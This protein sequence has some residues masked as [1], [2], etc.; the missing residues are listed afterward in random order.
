M[1]LL[2]ANHNWKSV[3]DVL[4]HYLECFFRRTCIHM[5]NFFLRPKS[6][7]VCSQNTWLFKWRPRKSDMGQVRI[8]S[9]PKIRS[10][11]WRPSI[12]KLSVQILI[13]WKCVIRED[14]I[15]LKMNFETVAGKL[16]IQI[17][18]YILSYLSLVKL[19]TSKTKGAIPYS[20]RWCT[21]RQSL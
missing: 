11:L 3:F 20:W 4:E 2:L 7:W 13:V 1:N 10:A 14:L 21:R 19:S 15:R 8:P 9:S 5:S 6:F 17:I 16:R 18:L 12:W